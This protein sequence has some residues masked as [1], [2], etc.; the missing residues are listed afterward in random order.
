MSSPTQTPNPTPTR[1]PDITPTNTLTPTQTS[2]SSPTPTVTATA[3]P[4][5]TITRTSSPTPTE[6]KTPTPTPTNTPTTTSTQTPT[7]SI[8]PTPTSTLAECTL[9]NVQVAISD[10]MLYKKISG[11]RAET[12]KFI[13]AGEGCCGESNTIVINVPSRT[14]TN[15]PTPTLT[16]TRTV[17]PTQTQTPTT[18]ATPTPTKTNTRTPTNTPTNTPTQT[19]T[20]SIT[21]SSSPNPFCDG[22]R[23]L[24]FQICNSNA[25]RDDNYDIILNNTNIGFVDLSRDQRIGSLFIAGSESVTTS[26]FECSI[27]DMVVY[28]FNES[29]VLDGVN[30]LKMINRQANYNGNYGKIGIRAYLIDS[31]NLKNPINVKD[32]EYSGGTG[33]SFTFTFNLDLCR[34]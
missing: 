24:V 25:A 11:R 34:S 26:D 32:L 16:P 4:S 18:T 9:R 28:R 20:P 33:Q 22:N 10:H 21:P 14:P 23:R 12:I 17:T 2:T 31:I 29:F 8:T 13:M 5:P 6:T 1:T 27:S 19:L 7:A 3:T 15:T 30:E